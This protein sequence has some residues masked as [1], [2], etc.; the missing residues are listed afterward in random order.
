MVKT[1]GW[2]ARRTYILVFI[3]SLPSVL[4]F[5]LCF[6]ARLS[7]ALLGA[8]VVNTS[9][10]DTAPLGLLGMGAVPLGTALGFEVLGVVWLGVV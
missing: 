4:L 5:F 2:V 1:V 7:L 9:P 6:V 10:A 8:P 3:L